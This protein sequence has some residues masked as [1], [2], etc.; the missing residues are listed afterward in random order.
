MLL[1]LSACHLITSFGQKSMW[2][3][4]LN[5][6]TK[7]CLFSSSALCVTL[8][9]L[10]PLDESK[11]IRELVDTADPL[12]V[13]LVVSL[14]SNVGGSENGSVH[15]KGRISGILEARAFCNEKEQL[16]RCIK[17]L[18]VSS[19]V[20]MQRFGILSTV[21]I[22]L[23]PC[24]NLLLIYLNG[25]Q[26]YYRIHF[27]FSLQHHLL[28]YTFYF[29]YG[30]AVEQ[31]LSPIENSAQKMHISCWIATVVGCIKTV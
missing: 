2:S 1:K 18:K 17:T 30:E 6:V 24:S 29:V 8:D 13:S 16:G 7:V 20:R 11:P 3:I 19:G 26:T 23:L 4:G 22:D 12:E 14:D 27:A 9:E 15:G 25:P 10:K 28:F 5:P 21:R 31:M